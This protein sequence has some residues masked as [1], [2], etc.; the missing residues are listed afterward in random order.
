[1]TLDV[2]LRVLKFWIQIT[3]LDWSKSQIYELKSNF[4]VKITHVHIKITN[5]QVQI[6]ILCLNCKFTV[7]ITI[8]WVQITVMDWND[9]V[10]ITCYKF[11]GA[12]YNF[13]S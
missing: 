10:S 12:F 1:M 6:T 7:R 5:L 9:N 11:T 8:L 13:M 2:L 4:R 3:K